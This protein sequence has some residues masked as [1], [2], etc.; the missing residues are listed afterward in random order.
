MTDRGEL[1][2]L[3]RQ[4]I[5]AAIDVH[6]NLGPGLL[7]TA[8]EACL[9]YELSQRGM[10]V[11]RQKQLPI[12]YKKVVVDAAFRLD[13]VVN[14][15]VIVELK[16]VEQVY[17]IHKAQL[18]TYLKLSGLELGLLINFNVRILKDGV[19]RVIYDKK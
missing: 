5:G 13:L 19:N 11:E 16:A 10:V 1:N 17:P 7:E 15:K 18:L 2:E 4:I 14:E 3:S 9:E 12:V 6:R 8:Y